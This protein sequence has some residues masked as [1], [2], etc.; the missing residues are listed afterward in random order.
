[1]DQDVE[2]WVRTCACVK[3]KLKR[4][5]RKGKAKL[6]PECELYQS[7]SIDTVFM[8]RAKNGMTCFLTIVD[9]ASREVELVAMRNKGAKSVTEAVWKWILRKGIPH[10]ICADQ[11]PAYKANVTESLLELLG[12]KVFTFAPY[13]HHNGLA[14]RMNG[15]VEMILR[16]LIANGE[17]EENWTDLLPIVQHIING[18]EN[19]NGISP[20]EYVTGMKVRSIE[21][22]LFPP[23][24]IGD[25]QRQ[26]TWEQRM[27]AVTTIREEVKLWRARE[28]YKE[29]EARDMKERRKKA[30]VFIPKQKI[31]FKM[32]EDDRKLAKI[33]D[34]WVEGVIVQKR[35]GNSYQVRKLGSPVTMVRM[36]QEIQPRMA[37]QK[38]AMVEGKLV[39]EDVEEQQDIED[40]EQIQDPIVEEVPQTQT[41]TQDEKNEQKYVTEVIGNQTSRMEDRTDQTATTKDGN[42]QTDTK[43]QSLNEVK[44]EKD[45]KT[46]IAQEEKMLLR[47]G[48]WV[49]LRH[50]TSSHLG[51]QCE[52]GH[53]N[54]VLF[55]RQARREA[56]RCGVRYQPIWFKHRGTELVEMTQDMMPRGEGWEKW[57]V[58]E[59]NLVEEGYEDVKKVNIMSQYTENKKFYVTPMEDMEILNIAV[60]T[61]N[62]RKRK[63][64]DELQQGHE[65][66]KMKTTL[67]DEKGDELG[68][69]RL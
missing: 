52:D 68:S 59:H 9:R 65:V 6:R 56:K 61:H 16:A 58:K 48:E 46:S 28:D 15:M 5:A 21:R 2:K 22:A 26:R 60:Q 1:M 53:L 11:D 23:S 13:S 50:G 64:Q 36:T 42:N 18:A 69:E 19:E 67:E 29:V 51:R 43:V 33:K 34:T 47:K 17:D 39:I 62:E 44:E 49:T 55:K 4:D 38:R 40:A 7:I 30:R 35:V 24:M 37:R 10:E 8:P 32:P 12:S 57:T 25:I 27:Q 54:V 31:F 3:A 63:Q 45:G 14:E 66:K 41:E 20:F